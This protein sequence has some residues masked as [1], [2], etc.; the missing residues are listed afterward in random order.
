MSIRNDWWH[1]EFAKGRPADQMGGADGAQ[2]MNH[3]THDWFTGYVPEGSYVLDV[4]CCNAHTL[5]NFKKHGKQV[6]YM[7]VDH[8]PELVEYC[9]QTYPEATFAQSEA[10]DLQDFKDSSFD[11]VLSR[12]VAEHLNHY[13]QHF[14]EM[15]R[16]AKKEVVIVGFLELNPD[17]DRLQYGVKEGG[18]L[19]PH[20]FNQYGQS[21]M[22]RFIEYNMTTDYEIWSDKFGIGHPII[23]IRKPS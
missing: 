2:G 16:V 23:I 11:Y 4:G 22:E 7:G 13:S 14:M 3:V 20:W 8:L 18:K 21:Q 1:T 9:K 19:L 17:Y 5:G 10:D 15:W 6:G 12:H